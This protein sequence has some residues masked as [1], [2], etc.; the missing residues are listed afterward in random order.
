[1]A[2]KEESKVTEVGQIGKGH[3]FQCTFVVFSL[4]CLFMMLGDINNLFD[5]CLS[6]PRRVADTF[7]K[8]GQG[9][10]YDCFYHHFLCLFLLGMFKI[11][12]K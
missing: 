6:I 8:S 4:F 9:S 3:S 2:K 11:N 10:H 7:V 12:D 5:V 1:M